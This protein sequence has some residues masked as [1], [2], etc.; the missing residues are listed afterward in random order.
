MQPVQLTSDIHW[1][2]AQDPDLRVFDIIMQAPR[3]TSY[4]AY[5]VC[6]DKIALIDTVK[7]GFYEQLISHIRT[8]IDPARIDYIILNHTEPDHSGTLGLLLEEAPKATVYGSRAAGMFLQQILNH[9]LKFNTV[10]NGE[11]LDLGNKQLQF[12]SAPNLHWPD[13]IFTYVPQ[14]KIL[15]T[16]D[17]FGSHY[18]GPQI[19]DDEVGDFREAF[20]YYFDHIIRPFKADML[21]A[22]DKIK[23]MAIDMIAPS[24]GPVLRTEVQHYIDSYVKWSQPP[25][26]EPASVVIAYISA[27]GNTRRM[28]GAIAEGVRQ[29]GGEAKL[30]DVLQVDI[31]KFR[32]ELECA[33]GLIVGSPTINA[34][35]VK[36]VWDL[37]SSL[38]TIKLKGKPAAAF[39]SYAWSGE[40]VKLLTERLKGLKFKVSEPGLNIKLVPSEADLEQ[41]RQLGRSFIMEK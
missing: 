18:C 14:D 29:A 16:C 10:T 12:I 6:A 2:G 13:S 39:G 5:L 32:D 38:A 25:A 7:P 26:S 19:F 31:D 36:P 33:S 24:H 15:F 35:A 28:A 27:Y 22:A 40:A 21:A 4:N 17:V 9:N 1:V 34:D 8:L 23:D 37:L 3:G 30:H 20:K 11:I 41:C